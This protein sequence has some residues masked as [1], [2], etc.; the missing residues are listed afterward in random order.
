MISQRKYLLRLLSIGSIEE[1]SKTVTEIS[2]GSSSQAVQASE[3]AK[4]LFDLSSE[5]DVIVDNSKLIKKYVGIV[6]NINEEGNKALSIL[7]QKFD[8]NVNISMKVKQNTNSLAEKSTSVVRIVETI[9]EIAEQ[10]NLLALNA[11]IEAARAGEIG[12]GFAVVAD[13]VRKLAEETST[14][15]EEITS[16]INEIKEEIYITKSNVDLV[17]GVVN[18]AN[19]KLIVTEKVFDTISDAVNK[20]LDETETLTQNIEKMSENKNMVIGIIEGISAIAEEA[21]AET[22]EMSAAM[23]CQTSN[24]SNIVSSAKRSEE[25]AEGLRTIITKFK[26]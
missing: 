22:E 14:A 11:A 7:Q 15:T 26:L 4:K 8:A 20:N 13:E 9:K 17:E 12:K 18:E 3:G 25:I 2:A 23:D 19:D 21:A 1:L 10:T 5:I 6:K 24:V 16:I